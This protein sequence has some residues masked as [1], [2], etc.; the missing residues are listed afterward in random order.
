MEFHV[1]L[2]AGRLDLEKIQAVVS[3]VDPSAVLDVDGDGQTLRVAAAVDAG[4]LCEMI[5]TAGYP[6]TPAQVKQIPSICCGGCS[7]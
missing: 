3:Q 4:E 2:P 7:G 1:T 5:G 6:V